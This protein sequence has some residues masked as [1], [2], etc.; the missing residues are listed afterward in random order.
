MD[1]GKEFEEIIAELYEKAGWHTEMRKTMKG[2]S[3]AE[4]QIDVYGEKRKVRKKKV[5]VE[6]KFRENDKVRKSH[7]ANFLLKLDDI[8]TKTEAHMVT[9]STFSSYAKQTAERYDIKMINRDQLYRLLNKYDMRRHLE[10]IEVYQQ[11][12]LT[13]AV[14]ETIDILGELG[15]LK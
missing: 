15:I 9:N 7:V 6:C 12:P 3:G 2:R 8:D 10:F 13:K 4:H 5:F 11:N 14:I 1:K